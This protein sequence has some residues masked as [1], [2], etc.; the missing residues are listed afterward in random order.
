MI[1]SATSKIKA[2]IARQSFATLDL[3][4]SPG[5]V[6]ISE[7]G[8]PLTCYDSETGKLRWRIHLSKE[9]H[10]LRLSYN[11]NLNMVL[12]VSW[13]FA[14]SGDKKLRYINPDKGIIEKEIV[15]NSPVEF[16]FAIDGKILVT[17]ERELID[18]ETGEKKTW[19]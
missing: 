6:F 11:E 8:S 17:A 16:Q 9:G 1:D 10:F 2:I 4:F 18:I 13:P 14:N 7:S 19:K 12:G 5:N 15:I 3:A